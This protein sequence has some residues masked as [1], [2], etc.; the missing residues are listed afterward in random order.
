MQE[1]WENIRTYL[2]VGSFRSRASLPLKVKACVVQD[3]YHRKPGLVKLG[4][5]LM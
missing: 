5:P 4:S 2:N 1:G 3:E